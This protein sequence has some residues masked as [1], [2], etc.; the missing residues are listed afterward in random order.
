MTGTAGL[1]VFKLSGLTDVITLEFSNPFVG[2]SSFEPKTQSKLVGV[3]AKVEKGA[4]ANVTFVVLPRKLKGEVQSAVDSTLSLLPP[5]CSNTTRNLYLYDLQNLLPLLRF[6]PGTQL[7]T[8][9]ATKL[10]PAGPKILFPLWTGV[11][12]TL[13]LYKVIT[14]TKSC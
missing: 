7:Y 13:L 1:I 11:L 12:V 2:S 4:I 6:F 5:S 10:C 8:V 14:S 9:L 3:R